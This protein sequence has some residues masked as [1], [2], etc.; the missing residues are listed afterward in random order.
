[1]GSSLEPP[2]QQSPIVYLA[3]CQLRVRGGNKDGGN[4]EKER[5]GWR[6]ER[7]TEGVKLQKRF[8]QNTLIKRADK[9][10]PT[11]TS[12]F[13]LH[14]TLANDQNTLKPLCNFFALYCT[15]V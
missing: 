15:L 2:W 9:A 11:K 5:E 4:Y 3:N 10:N 6:M 8:H 13:C 14:V 12:E 1:M 7:K